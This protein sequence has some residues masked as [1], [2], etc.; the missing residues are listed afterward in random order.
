MTLNVFCAN[1]GLMILQL[2]LCT[3]AKGLET[4]IQISKE[5]N[6]DELLEHLLELKNS[7]GKVLVHHR[8]YRKSRHQICIQK[9]YDHHWKIPLTGKC[10]TS[11]VNRGFKA[12]IWKKFQ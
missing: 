5:R 6:T 8:C 3:L 10:N 4:L 9:D 1:L 12:I 2:M 11:F 7:N